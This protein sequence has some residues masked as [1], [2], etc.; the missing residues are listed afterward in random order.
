MRILVRILGTLLLV[1]CVGA[2]PSPT[3]APGPAVAVTITSTPGDTTAFEPA[4][5]TVRAKGPI[6][7]TFRNASSVAHNLVFTTG[8]TATTRTIVEP[9]TSDRLVLVAPAPGAYPFVCTIH[10]GMEG[11]LVVQATVSG[12]P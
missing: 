3:A 10:D 2:G 6:E 12:D 1:G 11:T 5:T 9:G 8:L 4:K 7:V